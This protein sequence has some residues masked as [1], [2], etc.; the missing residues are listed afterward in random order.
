MVVKPRIQIVQKQTRVNL[1]PFVV[2]T[3]NFVMMRY[4]VAMKMKL[5]VN[6]N[7]TIVAM[8]VKI[9]QPVVVVT[10]K[11]AVLMAFVYP[12]VMKAAVLVVVLE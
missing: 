2:V 11:N 8:M 4:I 7:P 3:N 12:N 5:V 6:T 9:A 1:N 10:P